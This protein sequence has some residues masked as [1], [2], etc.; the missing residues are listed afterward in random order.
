MR[1]FERGVGG[2][3]FFFFYSKENIE[4]SGD[5][6]RVG[7]KNIGGLKDYEKKRGER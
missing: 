4:G 1:E 2:V 6:W 7:E 3:Y 5:F